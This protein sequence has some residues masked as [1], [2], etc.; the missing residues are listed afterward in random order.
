MHSIPAAHR[1]LFAASTLLFAASVAATLAIGAS[2]SGMQAMPMPGGWSMSMTWMRMPGQTWLE[3]GASF[4]AMWIVMMVAMM[5][6]SVAPM[7]WRFRDAVRNCGPARLA[8][9]TTLA[10]VAYFVVWAAIGLIAFPVGL[11]L[12]DLEMRSPALAGAVPIAVGVLILIAGALQFTAWKARRLACC[13]ELPRTALPADA[14]TA[15]RHGLQL[16][17]RCGAC[18]A[19]LTAVLL[20]IGVMDLRAMASV[21]VAITLERLAPA[22]LGVARIVGAVVAAGGLLLIGQAV[23]S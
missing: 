2:M 11:A 22:H 6:P 15:W 9:L 4:I 14:G 20:A 13:R 3:A 21:T 12:A 16:G 5:L 10:G 17:V 18:C 7:L 19:N 8:A 23:A 1:R